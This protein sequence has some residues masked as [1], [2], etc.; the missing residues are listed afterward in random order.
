LRRND[1]EIT[2]I[3]EI[4]GLQK[5]SNLK[6]LC[7]SNSKIREIKGLEQP[8]H[9]QELKLGNNPIKASDKD[10][11]GLNAQEI[12]KYCQEKTRKSQN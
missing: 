2:D 3:S 12:V 6:E 4:E 1:K 11:L 9:L 10:L 7:L 8:T 5:L